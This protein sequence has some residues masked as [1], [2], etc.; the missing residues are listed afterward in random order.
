[1]RVAILKS[2]LAAGLLGLVASCDKAEFQNAE[3]A[4]A[5]KPEVNLA[6][7]LMSSGMRSAITY[8]GELCD[9]VPV[10]GTAQAGGNASAELW[11][12]YSFFGTAGDTVTVFARRTGTC[13]MDPAFYLCTGIG[14]DTDSLGTEL[15]LWEFADDEVYTCG[16]CHADAQLSDYV[17]PSTGMYTVAL[18]SNQ[19]CGS[20][21]TYELTV[22]GIG[23]CTI[24]ID[25][26][27]TGVPDQEVSGVSMTELIYNCAETAANHGQFVS[28][29][30][31]L[32]N[33]WKAAGL[34]SNSEK[35]AIVSCAAQSDLP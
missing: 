17:L 22:T 16:A 7:V 12:Y 32:T 28:C 19:S 5:R 26:C 34:I 30:T 18:F 9:G 15:G 24:V 14:T 2:A 23:S 33:A 21:L 1:M 31:Q 8:A 25:G 4:K 13:E 10:T 20:N 35:A 11:E 29:V 27:D 6:E 3:L